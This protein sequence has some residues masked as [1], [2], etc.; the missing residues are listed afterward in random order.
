M[1]TITPPN[2]SKCQGVMKQKQNDKGIYFACPN[3][4]PENMGCEGEF[5]S[6]PK[7]TTD[8]RNGVPRVTNPQ[9]GQKSPSEGSEA[10]MNASIA[11]FDILQEIK[12]LLEQLVSSKESSKEETWKPP[13]SSTESEPPFPTEG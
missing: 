3:W 8:G 11:I 4:K 5:W 2:C 12:D 7:N 10:P 6:P 13:T 9:E 1:Q